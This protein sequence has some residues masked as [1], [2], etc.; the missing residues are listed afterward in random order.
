MTKV[1]RL[2]G[3]WDGRTAPNGWPDVCE[4]VAAV[5]NSVQRSV[6]EYL[7]SGTVFAVAAGVSVCRLCGAANGSP[8]QT[9]GVN[10]VFPQGL[11]HYV[12]DHGVRLPDEVLE[13][14]GRGVA[15]VVNL[16]L[17]TSGLL[18]SGGLTVDVQWWRRQTGLRSTGRP[19]A[20]LPGCR[21]NTTVAS[22]D[23]PSHAEIYIDRVPR[24]A[25]T[26]LV[27]LR[28][29]LGTSWPFS[30]LRNLLDAQPIHADTGNPANLNRT[31]TAVPKLRP[32]LFYDADGDLIP[33]WSGT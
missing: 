28:R 12:Q 18:E 31:L 11:A 33:V 6:A 3:Y 16:E 5:D 32:Y 10:F 29:L 22:W 4:F 27:E 30:D 8:E 13:I 15:S 14:A 1:V 7:R 26:I 2:I 9:D 24:D 20:H 19:V 23:L 17:L 21:R 25:V